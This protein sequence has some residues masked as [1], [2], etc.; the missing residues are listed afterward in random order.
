MALLGINA[1]IHSLVLLMPPFIHHP[2]A[3][4]LEELRDYLFEKIIKGQ[5]HGPKFIQMGQEELENRPF[6][7]I[8]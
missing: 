6:K 2:P 4:L 5:P 1:H 7:E 3:L 8:V